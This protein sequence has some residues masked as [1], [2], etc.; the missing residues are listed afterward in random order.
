MYTLF[1]FKIDNAYMPLLVDNH[2]DVVNALPDDENVLYGESDDEDDE[3]EKGVMNTPK[4]DYDNQNRNHQR[5]LTK[6]IVANRIS[7]TGILFGYTSGMLLILI[8]A[9]IAISGA[10]GDGGDSA[11]G[12][13]LVYRFSNLLTGLWWLFFGTV[14]FSGFKVRPAKT[15]LP[16]RHR[17][18]T[19]FTLGPRSIGQ[20][21]M[22]SFRKLPNS[23]Y[24]L[25]A[26]FFYSDG[27]NTIAAVGSIFAA[28][29][30]N[31]SGGELSIVLAEVP[32]F[33]AI[34]NYVFQKIYERFRTKRTGK[35]QKELTPKAMIE[36]IL[37]IFLPLPIYTIIG[38]IPGL[39]FGMKHKFEMYIFG[40]W[41]GLVLGPVN[42]FS[43]GLFMEL[44]PS[45]EES[46]WFAL[47]EI[48]DKGS[49]WIGPLLAG[50]IANLGSMRYAMVVVITSILFGWYFLR[51][52]NLENGRKQAKIYADNIGAIGNNNFL[53]EIDSFVFDKGAEMSSI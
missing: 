24:M 6:E 22:K 49:S 18:K 26:W 37:I 29:E 25:I 16:K 35:N 19:I 41:Y 39:P 12:D 13:T 11:K 42:A 51:K 48:T 40:M 15:Q 50:L 8:C 45:S 23:F 20:M 14:A 53:V 3:E 7:S 47:Y 33:A 31:M 52:V 4:S 46:R 44:I 28:K 43:R 27:I 17:L 2:P 38:F 32:F 5:T 1:W 21:L 36:W 34:G 9:G 10:L 30:L